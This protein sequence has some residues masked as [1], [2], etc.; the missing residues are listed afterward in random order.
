METKNI[1]ISAYSGLVAD[2]IKALKSLP[3]DFLP[4]GARDGV[5][6]IAEC[7]NSPTGCISQS[8]VVLQFYEKRIP[9]RAALIYHCGVKI[10]HEAR[11]VQDL[12]DMGWRNISFIY[13]EQKYRIFGHDAGLERKL[14]KEAGAAVPA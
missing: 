5:G 1:F 14:K 12:R 3:E 7:P 13:K 10:P 6:L 11:D 4:E 9:Q 8:Q 2:M